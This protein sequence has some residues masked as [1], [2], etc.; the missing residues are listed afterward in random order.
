M[1]LYTIGK[2]KAIP[3]QKKINFHGSGIPLLT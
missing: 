2:L 1:V 3:F